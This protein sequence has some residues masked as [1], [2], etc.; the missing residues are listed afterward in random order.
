MIIKKLKKKYKK[1]KS[2]INEIDF[3]FEHNKDLILKGIAGFQNPIQVEASICFA[4]YLSQVG[5][6]NSNYH[7]FLKFIETNNKWIVDALLGKRDPRLLFSTIRPNKYIIKKAFRLLTLWH[8][9]EIY[10]KVLLA[11]LGI[12]ECGY[13]KPD[14]GYSIYPLSITDLNN[15]GKY[16]DESKDQLHEDNMTLL[17]VLDKITGLGEYRG[18]LIK[19][20]LSKHAFNIRIAYFD[21]TKKLTDIIPQVLLIKLKREDY[22]INPSKEFIKFLEAKKD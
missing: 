2:V 17:D 13:H 5:I 4:F 11:L 18:S 19:N 16:L 15:L 20:V 10:I 6:N 22:E 1:R 21:N 3:I 14:D 7:L 9:K 8:P 12:I